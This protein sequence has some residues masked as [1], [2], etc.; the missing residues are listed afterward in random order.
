MVL[1]LDNRIEID[2]QSSM[3]SVDYIFQSPISKKKLKKKSGREKQT[4][5][6]FFVVVTEKGISKVKETGIMSVSHSHSWKRTRKHTKLKCV[7]DLQKNNNVKKIFGI[8]DSSL[9]VP[10]SPCE[11]IK[12]ILTTRNVT[13][14]RNSF[15]MF[16]LY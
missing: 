15:V 8:S 6:S 11:M 13:R 7:S 10:D 9:G 3:N 14:I 1:T 4:Y 16:F 5:F 12:L 2:F